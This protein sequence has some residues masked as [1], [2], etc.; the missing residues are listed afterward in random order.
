[1]FRIFPILNKKWHIQ[2]RDESDAAVLHEIL[3]AKEYGFAEQT[4][5][6]AK[7]AILDVGAH[8]GMFVLWCRA[9]N[10]EVPIF[11]FEPEPNNFSILKTH[12]A[13]NHLKNVIA[14]QVAVSD[15]VGET[16]LQISDDSMNHAL[17]V[18]L[19]TDAKTIKVQTTSLERILKQNHLSSVDLIKLDVEGAE[20]QI[21]ESTPK[22]T[23]ARIR[24][25]ACETHKIE[26]HSPEELKRFLES[27]GYK[28]LLTKNPRVQELGYLWATKR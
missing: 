1:M 22:E 5:R 21:L 26:G 25:I 2:I 27:I 11:A 4:I 3:E 12:I 23:F 7:A 14:K 24:A 6:N 13:E 8:S 10:A 9:I 19:D 28:V 16:Q 15:S 17:L 18:K 20:Y